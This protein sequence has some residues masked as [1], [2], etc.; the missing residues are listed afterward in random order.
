M[1]L[2]N[3]GMLAA[4]QDN[5]RHFQYEELDGNHHIHLTRPDAVAAAINDFMA[6]AVEKIA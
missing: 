4:F 5:C 6:K 3:R 2:D 1:E